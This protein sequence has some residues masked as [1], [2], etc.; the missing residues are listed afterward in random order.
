MKKVILTL[1]AVVAMSCTTA[2]AQ[3]KFGLKGGL[4][5]T[6]FSLSKDLVDKSN[7]AGFYIGPT[8]K[9]TLPVV[10]LGVDLSALYDQR[11]AKLETRGDVKTEETIKSQTIAIPLNLRYQLVGL[12]DTGSLYVFAGPQIAFN[13]GDKSIK[14]INWNYK[15]TNFSINVGLGA[16]VLNHLQ[17]NANYNIACG[18]TGE[19][20]ISTFGKELISGKANSWQVGLAYY[21]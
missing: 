14:E 6:S 8:V 1:L 2:N 17:V 18:K 4:N 15:D 13:V 21:F 11:S 12:G 5:V 7:Q 9:F 16:M 10:G 19:A 3:L 20:D